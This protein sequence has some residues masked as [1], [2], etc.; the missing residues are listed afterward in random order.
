MVDFLQSLSGIYLI[1]FDSG[2]RPFSTVPLFLVTARELNIKGESD[3][4]P[5][6]LN[7]VSKLIVEP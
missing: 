6:T 5:S 3:M 2:C 4:N 1:V 7:F